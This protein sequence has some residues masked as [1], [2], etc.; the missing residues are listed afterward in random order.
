MF[1]IKQWAR[2]KIV[3]GVD[4]MIMMLGH[5]TFLVSFQLKINRDRKQPTFGHLYNYY[6]CQY[7]V[8]QDVIRK[9]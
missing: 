7:E 8:A 3:N 6:L 4:Q 1:A 5:V 2:E 9:G